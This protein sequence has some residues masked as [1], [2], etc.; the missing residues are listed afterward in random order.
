MFHITAGL[1]AL[2]G[3]QL[4]RASFCLERTRE[5]NKSHSRLSGQSPHGLGKVLPRLSP[6][7]VWAGS[8][9]VSPS[10]RQAWQG[11]ACFPIVG[12]LVLKQTARLKEC[13]L[14]SFATQCFLTLP[15]G[16]WATGCC[17]KR[18]SCHAGGWREAGGGGGRAGTCQTFCSPPEKC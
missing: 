1:T 6:G 10:C 16:C 11:Q 8:G 17:I 4:C 7:E 18:F 13:P 5:L 15:A 2:Q 12:L 14:F 9:G 3:R